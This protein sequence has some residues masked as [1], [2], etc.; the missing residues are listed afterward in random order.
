MPA[1]IVLTLTFLAL[2][3]MV[4]SRVFA[5]ARKKVKPGYFKIYQN[6]SDVEIPDRVLRFGRHFQN[7]VEIPPIFYFVCLVAIHFKQEESVELWAWVF[8]VSR[9]LHSL[10]HITVNHIL[11]R[12]LTFTVSCLALFFM[13]SIIIGKVFL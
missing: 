9:V 1:T 10:V 5:V 3:L 13:W 12:M 11:L 7:L 2:L 8:A 6:K 4:C